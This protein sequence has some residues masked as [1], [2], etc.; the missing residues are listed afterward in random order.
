MSKENK[1][2]G[3]NGVKRY[4]TGSKLLHWV[5]AI[6]VI[7]MLSLSFFLDDVPDEYKSTAFMMH[8]SFGLTVLILMIIRFVWILHKGKPSLPISIPLWE[9]ILSHL[10]QYSFYILLI[11]MPICGW[12]MSVA[13]GRVPTFFGLFYLPLPIAENKPLSK[14]MLQCH[15]II[16]WILI[17]LIILHVAGA[18]KHH[19]IDKDKVLRRMLPGG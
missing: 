7:T 18:I 17:V 15:Q 16:A 1:M 3:M 8:K 9:K 11:A 6:I 4:S 19:F 2:A 13:G 14:L 10:V 12:I 5:I